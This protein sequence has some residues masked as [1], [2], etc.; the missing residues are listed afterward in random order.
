MPERKFSTIQE[1][2]KTTSFANCCSQWRR[3][4]TFFSTDR[5]H[6]LFQGKGVR[7]LTQSYFALNLCIPREKNVCGSSLLC[8]VHHFKTKRSTKQPYTQQLTIRWHKRDCPLKNEVSSTPHVHCSP[9]SLFLTPLLRNNMNR[10][11]HIIELRLNIKI[12]FLLLNFQSKTF[13]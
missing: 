3:I 2:R 10:I 5:E 8:L 7:S 11:L 4:L 6:N 1:P 12:S 13:K 9:N